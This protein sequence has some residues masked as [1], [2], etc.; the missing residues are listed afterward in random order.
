MIWRGGGGEWCKGR[1]EGRVSERVPFKGGPVGT[2]MAARFCARCYSVR[3]SYRLPDFLELILVYL[4]L[5]FSFFP[6]IPS[7]HCPLPSFPHLPPT[8]YFS[9]LPSSP[10]SLL[11]S[12]FP[13]PNLSPLTFLLYLPPFLPSTS[14]FSSPRR[15]SHITK[16]IQKPCRLL[17]RVFS[18]FS[19]LFYFVF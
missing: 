15:P 6:P 10:S 2:A 11:P 13:L 18:H 8:P 7:P 12:F 5:Y 9:S 1:G 4:R 16:E 17:S 14:P 19:S 3:S